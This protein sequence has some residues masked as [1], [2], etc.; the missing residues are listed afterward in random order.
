MTLFRTIRARPGRMSAALVAG[1][2]LPAGFAPLGLAPVAVFSVAVLFFLWQGVSPR[3]AAWAG[4]LWGFG[5]FLAGTWWLYISIHIFGEAPIVLAIGLMLGLVT[6]MGLYLALTGW[7]TTRLPVT[8]LARHLLLLPGAW[9]LVEWLRGWLFSGFPWLSLGYAQTDTL[10][11]RL[12]PVAG[13]YGVSLASAVLAGVLV[14]LLVGRGRGRLAAALAG[15]G[16]LVLAWAAGLPAWSRPAGEPLSVALVQGAVSQDIKWLSRSL[17]PTKALYRELTRARLGRDIVVWPEAAI[18]SVAHRE[19]DYLEAVAAEARAAGTDLVLGMLEREFDP[20]RYYNAVLSFGETPGSYRKRHLVP[21]GE[22]F[23]VPDFVREWMRLMSL[24]YT[25]ISPGEY[26]QP[27]LTVA[28]YPAA[29]SVCYEDAFGAEQRVFLPRAAFLVNVSND[30]WFGDSLAPH[31][32]LQIARMRSMEAA[33]WQLRATNT[34]VSAIIRPDGAVAARSPQFRTHVLE[35]RILP[36]T[37]ATPYA[38]AGN[39]PVVL[40]SLLMAM[41]AARPRRRA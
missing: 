10:L 3:V 39:T 30:A 20:D 35:G 28:G 17:E 40:A 4:F 11:G 19:A 1:A 26:V 31:Q 38:L 33:R 6:I 8:G 41:A 36:L 24:P 32:H 7:I 22:Y 13:V 14:Q 15:A 29:I 2:C 34:G 23:P 18:P 21:F 37:G 12:A 27:P 5:A 25:D 16:V 9:V